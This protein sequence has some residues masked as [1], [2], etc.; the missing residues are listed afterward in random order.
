ME[1]DTREEVEERPDGDRLMQPGGRR[2]VGKGNLGNETVAE[3]G[4]LHYCALIIR[5]RVRIQQPVRG[6]VCH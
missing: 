2:T 3:Y 5:W 4:N 1:V 6:K